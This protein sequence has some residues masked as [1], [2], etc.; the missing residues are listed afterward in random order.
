MTVRVYILTRR[1]K[2]CIEGAIAEDI[3]AIA[4][5]DDL[6]FIED[7]DMVGPSQNA[8]IYAQI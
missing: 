4:H 3:I 6:H 8:V 2:K 1:Q 7:E 5:D